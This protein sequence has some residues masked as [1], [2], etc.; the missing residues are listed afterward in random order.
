MIHDIFPFI[1][2][3][4]THGMVARFIQGKLIPPIHPHMP[5]RHPRHLL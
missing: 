4:V 5:E 1:H 3:P 2:N